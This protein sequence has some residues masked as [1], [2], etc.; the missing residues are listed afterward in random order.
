M[1]KCHLAIVG[2]TG[3]VGRTA[4]DVLEEEAFPLGD[5]FFLASSRSVDQSIFF[6]KKEHKVQ[7]LDTFDFSKADI[8]IFA[9]GADISEAYVPKATAAGC[10]VVDNTTCYRQHPEVPL[11]VP[12]VNIDALKDFKMHNVVANPNC[13]TVQMVIALKPILDAYGI[14]RINVATYQAVSGAG[15]DAMEELV[16]QNKEIARDGTVRTGKIYPKQIACNV[17]PH[18]DVFM[19]NGYT[20]EEMKMV[21]ETRKIFA[22]DKIQ[23]NPTAVR[24]AVLNGHAEAVHVECKIA[25]VLEDVYAMLEKAPGIKVVDGR[26]PLEYP[27]PATEASGSNLVYV[28]RVRLDISHPRGLNIWVVSD[29]LRKGSATNSIQIAKILFNEYL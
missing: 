4:R 15:A 1:K 28:G 24:V 25:P 20:K 17:L 21:W 8:A 7:L 5:I 19:D 11:I 29:N 16:Q 12:E 14:S 13:S 6:G 10:V 26:K 22:D 23:I 27:T 3:L 2:A 9:A 18:V